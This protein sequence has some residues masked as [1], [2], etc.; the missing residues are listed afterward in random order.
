MAIKD[1]R[2]SLGANLPSGTIQVVIFVPNKDRDG[3]DVDQGHWRDLALETLG[4]LFRGATAFPPGEGVWRDDERGGTLLFE[5]VI[6]VISYVNARELSAKTL[7]ELRRF[8]HKFGR[9][10][11]QGEVGIIIGGT[12]YGISRYDSV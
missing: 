10:A 12:Y 4:R 2:R 3:N 9:E 5:Q 6:I 7:H 1:Y 11:N 8:L